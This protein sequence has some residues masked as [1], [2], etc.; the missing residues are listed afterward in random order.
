[1][2]DLE[3]G[4]NFGIQTILVRTGYGRE[5]EKKLTKALQP[6]RIVND[7]SEAASILV[8]TS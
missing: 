6:E 5:T 2:S 8:K 7:L 3:A 4:K 1:M